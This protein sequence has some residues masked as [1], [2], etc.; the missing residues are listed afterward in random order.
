MNPNLRNF[1]MK[2]PTREM[3]VPTNCAKASKLTFGMTLFGRPFFPKFASVRS[4]RASRFLM[5]V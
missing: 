5:G 4:A 2:K 3:V 1:R